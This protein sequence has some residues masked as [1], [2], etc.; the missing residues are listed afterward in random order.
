VRPGDTV[1]RL[2]GDEFVVV[3]ER[4][5]GHDDS[6]LLAQRILNV[7]AAPFRVGDGLEATCTASI[8]VA[9]VDAHS[10]DSV[11]QAA[12]R[13]LYRAKRRGRNRF[14]SAAAAAGAG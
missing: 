11:L 12:D 5:S 2:G 3:A 9:L 4:L 6:V 14:E 1:A 7:L 13:A 10:A 8:G